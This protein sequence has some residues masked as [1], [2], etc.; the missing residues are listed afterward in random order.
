MVHTVWALG[1]FWLQDARDISSEEHGGVGV[2]CDSGVVRLM[3]GAQDRI[4]ITDPEVA[5]LKRPLCLEACG[6]FLPSGDC[7]LLK[8]TGLGAVL[9]GSQRAFGVAVEVGTAGELDSTLSFVLSR[10]GNCGA[11]E[12]DGSCDGCENARDLNH[13]DCCSSSQ[14]E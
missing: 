9:A 14:R 1:D 8:C 11:E 2:E 5:R 6:K 4:H 3:I 7:T 12:G 10:V 13:C